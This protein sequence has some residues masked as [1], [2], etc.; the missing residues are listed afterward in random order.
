MAQS[1]KSPI[2][3]NLA[4][5]DNVSDSKTYFVKDVAEMLNLKPRTIRYYVKQGWLKPVQY[6]SIRLQFTAQSLR[7]LNTVMEKRMKKERKRRSD[8]M[9]D[10]HVPESK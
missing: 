4:A 1:K 5:I 6:N 3:A 10:R 9:K 2:R 8:A 7:D